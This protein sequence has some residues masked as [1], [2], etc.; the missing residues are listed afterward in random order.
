MP[1][2]LILQLPFAAAHVSRQQPARRELASSTES[3]YQ[4]RRL[5][6]DWWFDSQ[7]GTDPNNMFYFGTLT[8]TYLQMWNV[9]LQKSRDLSPVLST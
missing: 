9:L 4:V 8:V 3:L 5:S 1:C 7:K 6:S 2:I